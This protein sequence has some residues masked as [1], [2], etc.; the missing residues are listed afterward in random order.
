MEELYNSA[1]FPERERELQKR[2]KEEENRKRE[3]LRIVKEQKFAEIEW[4]KRKRKEIEEYQE[5]LRLREEELAI[6]KKQT[7]AQRIIY[8]GGQDHGCYIITHKG[9]V[10]QG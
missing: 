10:R 3:E 7:E 8:L 6:I 5:R 2:K 4:R 9:K 1:M